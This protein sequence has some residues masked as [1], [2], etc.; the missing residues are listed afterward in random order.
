ME[1]KE[2]ILINK[3]EQLNNEYLNSGEYHL[4]VYVKY[5]YA[6]ASIPFSSKSDI[7]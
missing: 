7:L 3:I 1:D 2:K 4:G 6:K 5:L